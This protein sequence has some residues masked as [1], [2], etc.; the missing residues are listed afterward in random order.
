VCEPVRVWPRQAAAINRLPHNAHSSDPGVEAAAA[1]AGGGEAMHWE[2]QCIPNP[3]HSTSAHL[4]DPRAH[5]AARDDVLC[6]HTVLEDGDDAAQHAVAQ[7]AHLRA[8]VRVCVCACVCAMRTAH[9]CVRAAM[10]AL[11]LKP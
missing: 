3:S 1:L 10:K 2:K 8:C 11:N 7:L 4:L 5:A 6:R 9:A